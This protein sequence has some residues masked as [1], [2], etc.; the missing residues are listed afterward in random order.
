MGRLCFHMRCNDVVKT[1]KVVSFAIL[2]L[3]RR[4]RCRIS[5]RRLTACVFDWMIPFVD[6]ISANKEAPRFSIDQHRDRALLLTSHSSQRGSCWEVRFICANRFFRTVYRFFYVLACFQTFLHTSHALYM[7]V[8]IC[9]LISSFKS[10]VTHQLL[11]HFVSVLRYSKF[12]L[13]YCYFITVSHIG[14]HIKCNKYTT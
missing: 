8:N 3:L 9:L 1:L 12:L 4:C 14:L 7:L 6:I 13:G 2:N 5:R 10:Q 11:A